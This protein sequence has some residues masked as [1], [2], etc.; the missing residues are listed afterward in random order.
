MQ[1]VFKADPTQSNLL[2]GCF[3]LNARNQKF[4]LDLNDAGSIDEGIVLSAIPKQIQPRDGEEE[5]AN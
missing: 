3:A 4:A 1:S 2:Q 5:L